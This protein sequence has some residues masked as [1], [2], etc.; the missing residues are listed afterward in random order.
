MGADSIRVLDEQI[1]EYPIA[2]QWTFLIGHRGVGK[3]TAVEQI[4]KLNSQITTVDLD[5]AIRQRFGEDAFQLIGHNEAEFRKLERAALLDL[6]DQHDRSDLRFVVSVGA[7]YEGAFPFSAE[8][9]WLRRR[10]DQH[11]RIFLNRPRLNP[12]TDPLSEYQLRRHERE[13]RYL[14]QCHRQL[15]LREGA[16]QWTDLEIHVWQNTAKSVGGFVSLP[17]GMKQPLMWCLQKLA[18]G[19]TRIELRDDWWSKDQILDFVSRLPRAK[20]LVAF[21]KSPEAALELWS[22]L[23][24]HAVHGLK[25]PSPA[26]QQTVVESPLA[27]QH[28][29]LTSES[30]ALHLQSQALAVD[31]PSEW[32]IWPTEK[33]GSPTVISLHGNFSDFLKWDSELRNNIQTQ[34]PRAHLKVA[35]HVKDFDELIALDL[36]YQGDSENRSVL[37]M[38]DSGK[39]LWYRQVMAGQMAIQF[40]QDGLGPVLDQPTQLEWMAAISPRV[41]TAN[42][43]PVSALASSNAFA[44]GDAL[45]ASP[46]ETG[47][48]AIVLEREIDST[49]VR[50]L[51]LKSGKSTTIGSV[52]VAKCWAAV[53]GEPVVHSWTPAFHQK[54]F[55][56]RQ[57]FV[58]H[59]A[60]TKHQIT[61]DVLLFLH[62]LGLNWAAVT[63]PLKTEMFSLCDDCTPAALTHQAVNILVW[64]GQNKLH[65]HFTDPLGF[66]E[67]AKNIPQQSRIAIWGGGGVLNLLN[68]AVPTAC[69][70]SAREGADPDTNPVNKNSDHRAESGNLSAL[71]G[72]QTDATGSKG[73]GGDDTQS[74]TVATHRDD[75]PAKTEWD[76]LIWATGWFDGLKLPPKTWKIKN[77]IDLNYTEN[78]PGLW[79]AQVHGCH[80][81]SGAK[82][83]AAQA[84]AQ[85]E[86]WRTL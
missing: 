53:L 54:Y 1:A 85:Q 68:A 71:P 72:A 59:V 24:R 39:W 61:H 70:F 86:F 2:G 42:S 58:T 74:A 73:V 41:S 64:T 3:S 11:G 83:F 47:N 45:P 49:A 56:D 34:A 44:K 7:G 31:W 67:L 27:S 22:E 66:T 80:Y 81:Q 52:R 60:L 75:V 78:S 14:Q 18:V 57:A 16:T 10:T 20:V 21:R 40:W 25:T 50:K 23:E 9:V 15:V 82:M 8:V 29:G 46:W 17:K 35:V 76:Y 79:V 65:G 63:S 12:D 37:P 13:P 30:I 55:S 26:D 6:L 28:G 38:S 33:S 77:V 51:E 48:T 43:D 32:G 5:A 36:W 84:L 69:H 4:A 62:K 19:V